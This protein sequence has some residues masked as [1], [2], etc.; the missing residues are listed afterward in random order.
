M[1]RRSTP[2][3]PDVPGSGVRRMVPLVPGVTMVMF[4]CGTMLEP[5]VTVA[6][7]VALAEEKL[8]GPINGAPG[9]EL[10]AGLLNPG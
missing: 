5:E 8:K 7:I 9:A 10:V 3:D 4:A 6:V 2:T 1:A